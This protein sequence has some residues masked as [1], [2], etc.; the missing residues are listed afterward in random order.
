MSNVDHDKPG[1]T[2]RLVEAT[3]RRTTKTLLVEFQKQLDTIQEQ[4]D[5]MQ[6]QIDVDRERV[7]VI[8][9]GITKTIRMM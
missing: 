5:N 1:P 8:F 7:S 2:E 4:L 3:V 9:D 6:E